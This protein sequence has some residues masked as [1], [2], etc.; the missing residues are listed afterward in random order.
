MTDPDPVQS[1]ARGVDTGRR[2]DQDRG[3]I[4]KEAE[5]RWRLALTAADVFATDPSSVGGIL[6]S[7]R[8]GPV[9]LA[10][11]AY[12][13]SALEGFRVVDVPAHVTA[14]RLIGS[15]DLAATLAAGRPIRE[16]GLLDCTDGKV[17]IL[18]GFDRMTAP[19]RAL[20][21]QAM[22]RPRTQ[23]PGVV[24]CDETEEHEAIIAR[25]MSPGATED[26]LG[27]W[28]DL[29]GIDLAAAGIQLDTP[30][31]RP[32]HERIARARS[33]L[34]RTRL[35]DN[36]ADRLAET[37]V[38][39]GINSLRAPL[40]TL[41]IARALTALRGV[42]AVSMKDI[43]AAVVLGLVPRATRLPDQTDDSSEAGDDRPPQPPETSDSAPNTENDADAPLPPEA[44][45]RMVEAARAWLPE[46][47]IAELARGL[48]AKVARGQSGRSGVAITSRKRGRHYGSLRGTPAGGQKL[49]VIETLRVAAP[50]QRLRGVG[51]MPADLCASAGD[52]PPSDARGEGVSTTPER[53]VRLRVRREDFR[54]YRRKDISETLTVFVVDASGS[55]AV[56]RLAEAKGAVEVLLGQSYVRRDHVALVAVRGREAETLLPPTR[57]LTR[58]RRQLSQ[59]PGGGGT[60][61]ADGLAKAGDIADAALR[62][63]MQAVVVVLTDGQANITADGRH[64]RA[65][66]FADA[67]QAARD[68]SHRKIP[69]LV[70]D[71]SF[72]AQRKVEELAAALGGRHLLLPR[73]EGAGLA[74]VVTDLRGA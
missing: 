24:A 1:L 44:M 63:G 27:L 9:V 2:P 38:A 14:D 25:R 20:V 53:M 57:S 36:V 59:L 50:W 48:R 60:P 66:A 41:A 45:E 51:P 13:H 26:R 47:L 62:R 55:A 72:R 73:V 5:A 43:E 61:L 17:L 10:W 39:L 71:T 34:A 29:D 42:E 64:A 11:L 19:M 12:T 15:I 3:A 4:L 8:H 21:T 49:N 31:Q 69:A 35:P 67:L 18:A 7:A 54:I 16:A 30:S 74:K 68:L 6:V 22:D 46:T 40:H 56:Q 23:R 32:N 28:I 52:G 33:C 37:A 65:D 70:V 58:A